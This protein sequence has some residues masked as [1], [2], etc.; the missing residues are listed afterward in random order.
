MKGKDRLEEE[1]MFIQSAGTVQVSEISEKWEITRETVR[2]DLD[3]LENDGFVTRT[4]GGAVWNK[5]QAQDNVRF[6]ERRRRNLDAKRSIALAAADLLSQND[7]I[8]ADASTTVVEA[9]KM[10]ADNPNLI[11]VTNSSEV[12]SVLNEAKFGMISTGGIFNPNSMSFQGALAKK[13]IRQY[14]VKLAVIS[15]KSLNM[16]KGVLDSYE[17]EAEIKKVMLEQSEKVALLA[18]HTK[19]DETAFLK[20]ID[21]NKIDYLITDQKPSAAWIAFCA[22]Q[23]IRLMY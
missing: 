10:V 6:F 4:H 21:L 8:F 9:L 7:T 17:S 11:V 13:T 20:L 1:K 5:T 16:E 12:F 14:N 22:A 23:N 15:C 2:R 19:F 18:D 3:K